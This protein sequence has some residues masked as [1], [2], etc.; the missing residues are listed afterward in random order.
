MGAGCSSQVADE[1]SPAWGVHNLE[2]QDFVCLPKTTNSLREYVRKSSVKA[3]FRTMEMKGA[4]KSCL[5]VV[6]RHFIAESLGTGKEQAL[7]PE[8]CAVSVGVIKGTGA[9]AVEYLLGRS[10]WRQRVFEKDLIFCFFLPIAT[11]Q[12]RFVLL[13]RLTL[14]DL[15]SASSAAVVDRISKGDMGYYVHRLKTHHLLR[16]IADI[17]F[18]LS[19]S[20]FE[21]FPCEEEGQE[22]LLAV[23]PANSPLLAL[24]PFRLFVAI[25][26]LCRE[27]DFEQIGARA[28]NCISIVKW[29]KMTDLKG[30]VEFYSDEFLP[31]LV[32]DLEYLGRDGINAFDSELLGCSFRR[33]EFRPEVVAIVAEE[34]FIR[35]RICGYTLA[36]PMTAPS[37]Q[38]SVLTAIVG[39]R[40][41]DPQLRSGFL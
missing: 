38:S 4:P 12:F 26:F 29:L 3:R 19:P 21:I 23:F 36:S 17:Q 5:Q 9:A 11:V 40:I 33:S 25:A 8:T 39:R 16:K 2:S 32:I 37:L 27:A 15:S 18:S 14:E 20:K 10:D 7:A 41:Q 22:A 6:L 31:I 13:S 24:S 30:F 1:S 35:P 28:F 34:T